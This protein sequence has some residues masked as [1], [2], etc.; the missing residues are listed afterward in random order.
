M[1]R[2]DA[3]IS[4]SLAQISSEN[5]RVSYQIAAPGTSGQRAQTRITRYEYQTTPPRQ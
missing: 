5:S 2:R 3:I 4:V 1:T